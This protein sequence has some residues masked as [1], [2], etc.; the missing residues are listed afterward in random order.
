MG[1]C[2]LSL[3]SSPAGHNSVLR[4]QTQMPAPQKGITP[5][6]GSNGDG[7]LESVRAPGTDVLA[8]SGGG[9]VGL[10]GALEGEGWAF[11]YFYW[12]SSRAWQRTLRAAC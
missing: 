3:F 8:G 1:H 7:D 4:V 10:Q 6:L 12:G 2:P 9:L 5:W 11:S